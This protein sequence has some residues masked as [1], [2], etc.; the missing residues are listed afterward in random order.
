MWDFLRKIDCFLKI[1]SKIESITKIYFYWW[2]WHDKRVIFKSLRISKKLAKY[3]YKATHKKLLFKKSHFCGGVNKRTNTKLQKK[4]KSAFMIRFISFRRKQ[5]TCKQ[6]LLSENS[7]D[8]K[9]TNRPTTTIP[10][11]CDVYIWAR[12]GCWLLLTNTLHLLIAGRQ[13]SKMMNSFY[14][15]INF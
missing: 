14:F 12:A 1:F 3:N 9:K 7:D 11:E 4:N 5:N 8:D 13:A 10:Y 2:P 15:F 6:H